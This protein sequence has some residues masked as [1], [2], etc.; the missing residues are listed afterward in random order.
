MVTLVTTLVVGMAVILHPETDLRTLIV[1]TTNGALDHLA[2]TGAIAVKDA[3][4]FHL[5]VLLAII[6]LMMMIPMISMTSD[7]ILR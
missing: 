2:I 1:M 4:G 6:P 3:R 5:R 7:H